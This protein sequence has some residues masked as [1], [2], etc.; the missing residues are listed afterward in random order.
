VSSP[1]RFEAPAYHRLVV[2]RLRALEPASWSAF[3]EAADA[4]ARDLHA[5]LLRA[6]YRLDPG[7]HPEVAHAAAAAAGALGVTAPVTVYQ[8][9]GGRQANATLV[10]APDEAVVALSGNLLGL[11][12]GPE[13]TAVLGH[14]LA[15]HV[16]WTG[17]GG[18]LFVA[19]RLLD[20]LAL[21]AR[22]PPAYLETARRW[23]LAT[24]LA[25]D[26]GALLAC[27]D[28]RTA[29]AALVKTATGPAAVDPD[30]YLAQ[31][32]SVDPAAGVAAGRT[33][34]ETVL[35]AR[36]L[37][38]GAA[39]GDEAVAGLLGG[40]LDVETLDLVDRDRLENLTR[41]M[42]EA[43]LAPPGVRTDAVLAHARQFFPDLVPAAGGQAAFTVPEGATAATRRYLAYVLLDLA[44][45][46]PDLEDVGLL[47][48]LTLAARTGLGGTVADA[49]AHEKL[50]P[51]ARLA[52][53]VRRSETGAV[54]D[55]AGRADVAVHPDPAAQV[56]RVAR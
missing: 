29:V 9:E 33:H 41:R 2:D 42:I 53:L 25:A 27:G 22:T 54:D 37:Q 38:Q 17:D 10:H 18:A 15:H 12:T 31:A 44:T 6:A 48:A 16:L 35:R 56:G 28:L 14:E 45:V 52:T 46:D 20:A 36:A 8:L 55:P 32:A 47:A 43:M 24:E 21:D 5:Q 30:A 50:V 23:G 26:A 39:T 40:G 13:L 51:A 19:D 49:A 3:A 7:A 11:L 34:P 1:G 4:Q